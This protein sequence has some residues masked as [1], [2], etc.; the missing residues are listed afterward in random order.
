VKSSIQKAV[1]SAVA[2]SADNSVQVLTEAQKGPYQPMQGSAINPSVPRTPIEGEI[3]PQPY[4]TGGSSQN[5]PGFLAGSEG[6]PSVPTDGFLFRKGP[7]DPHYTVEAESCNPYGTVGR[8][9][10][11]GWYTRL[12]MFLNHTAANQVTTETGFKI[13]GPQQ[14][15]SYMRSAL[16]PIG[17]FG[18]QTAPPKPQPQ[19]VRYNRIRPS[20][21]SDAYGSGVLNRDTFGAGQT[22]GGIGGYNYTPTPGPPATNSITEPPVT[23]EAV[24]G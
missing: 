22:A 24:W 4:F 16:P 3:A 19:A 6:A 11:Y 8:P 21:G 5:R 10:T 7:I 1:P 17:A 20:I 14:R 12:Q 18:I 15:T 23:G 2:F 13:N 9:G